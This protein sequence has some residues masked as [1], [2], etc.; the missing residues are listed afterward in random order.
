MMI[1]L[2]KIPLM[3]EKYPGGSGKTYLY[4]TLIS[5]IR[6]TGST[7]LA[8]AST[9]IAANLLDGGR[10]YHSLFKLPVPLLVTSTSNMRMTSNDAK[11]IKSAKLIIWDE[12]TM[13]PSFALSAVNKLLK[14]VMNNNKP[15]GG[16]T[17]LLGGDFR[18]TLPL[19]PHG[20]RSAIV[21]ASLKF[22]ELWEKFQIL[23]LTNNVRSVD[24]LFSD[25]LINVGDGT[26]ESISELPEDCIEVPANIVCEGSIVTE[27]FGDHIKL[28]DVCTFAKMAIV[29][30]K[31]SDDDHVNEE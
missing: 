8:V 17:L 11:L 26:I 5:Y 27:I 15:F 22:H 31:N 13:A 9:G 23:N 14:E 21:E 25:W 1:V 16:I 18:Q 12:S 20:S 24:T 28:S 2:G 4:K 6:S 10:T 19:V 30:P 29:F 7:V 3:M